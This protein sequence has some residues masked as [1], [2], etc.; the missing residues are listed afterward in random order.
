MRPLLGIVV[1]F[2]VVLLWCA[3][4]F[5]IF[6]L[7]SLMAKWDA[8]GATLNLVEQYAVSARSFVVHN[9]ILVLVGLVLLTCGSV[10]CCLVSFQRRD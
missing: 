6:Q 4:I 9:R 1:F 3:T 7:P 5:L 2:F 8:T 10:F